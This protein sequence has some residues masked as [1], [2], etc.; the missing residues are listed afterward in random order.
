MYWEN[1]TQLF[2]LCEGCHST[3]LSGVL[4]IHRCN[5]KHPDEQVGGTNRFQ[6]AGSNCTSSTNDT[7]FARRVRPCLSIHSR[8]QVLPA[9]SGSQA[10]VPFSM[11][12]LSTISQWPVT[13]I[14]VSRTRHIPCKHSKLTCTVKHMMTVRVCPD[15]VRT[16]RMEP[17]GA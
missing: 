14:L 7:E 11:S 4:K 3:W 17:G 16:C 2:N 12:Y 1:S 9:N 6:A 13:C 15:N 5:D 10:G 8:I